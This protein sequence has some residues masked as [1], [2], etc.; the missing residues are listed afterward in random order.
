LQALNLFN[1]PFVLQQSDLLADRLK[2]EAGGETEGQVK[3]AFQ[4]MLGRSPDDYE[5]EISN[6]LISKEGL[7]AFCRAMLNSSEF[8]F[9]F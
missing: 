3:L 1:S 7:A 4:W 6:E 9:I 8:L 2:R 5:R